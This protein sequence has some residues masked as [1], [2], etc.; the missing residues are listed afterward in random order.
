MSLPPISTLSTE[1]TERVSSV[2]IVIFSADCISMSCSAKILTTGSVFMS[3]IS[4]REA[5]FISTFEFALI[6][7]LFGI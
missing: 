5:E 6:V 3:P 7:I 4:I 1:T 2:L